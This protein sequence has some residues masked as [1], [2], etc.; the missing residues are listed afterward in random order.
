MKEI[1]KLIHQIWY[2]G[3]ENIPLEY[4]KYSKSWIKLNPDYNH[5]LWDEN[6]ID[7]LIRKKFKN[8]YTLYLNFPTMIQKID[9]AKYCIIYEYGGIYIDMDCECI[10]SISEIFLKKRLLYVVD[11]E[12]DI[13]EKIFANY[14][15]K[16]LFNNGWF[17]SLPKI[18]IWHLL[19]KQIKRVN[20]ERQWYETNIAYIFRTTG[21][22]IFS[23][24]ITSYI[25]QEPRV[26]ILKSS[27]IDPIKWCDYTVPSQINYND[28]PNSYSIHHYG[29]KRINGKS[30]Q[31]NIEII[32]GIT[33]G[34]VKKLWIFIILLIGL[35]FLDHAY[36]LF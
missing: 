19:L 35:F 8:Y 7:K 33:L 25:E 5:L 20:L 27:E 31:S 21:P 14:Y 24:V 18:P 9:F 6:S 36:P 22:K 28:Y 32:A 11:L 12:I 4:L 23:E 15:G 2:Q 30:W 29:S 16:Q 13:F 10:K 3:E 17:A 34:Y 26:Y 1:P